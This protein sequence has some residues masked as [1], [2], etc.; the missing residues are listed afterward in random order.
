MEPGLCG[1]CAHCQLVEGARSQFYLCT[2]AADD[3]RFRKYPPLPVRS[4]PGHLEGQPATGALVR[5][6]GGTP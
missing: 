6:E 5:S 4:C 1:H 3:A 2:L